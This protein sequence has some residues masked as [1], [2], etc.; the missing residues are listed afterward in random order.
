MKIVSYTIKEIAEKFNIS[1]HTLRYYEKEGLIPPVQRKE[2]GRRLYSETDLVWIQMVCCMRAAGMSVEYVKKYNNLYLLGENTI[3]ERRQ[4]ILHQKEIIENQI[5]EYQD[6]L[7][8]LNKKLEHYETTSQN[9]SS[10]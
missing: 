9:L 2:N 7:K 10:K 1:Q 6:L 4:I 5:K 8:L 3:P